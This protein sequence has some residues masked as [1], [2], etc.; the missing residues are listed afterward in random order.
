M[1][2]SVVNKTTTTTTNTTTTTTTGLKIDQLNSLLKIKQNDAASNNK[3]TKTTTTTNNHNSSVSLSNSHSRN[4]ANLRE[5]LELAHKLNQTNSF[6]SSATLDHS[7]KSNDNNGSSTN[8]QS[9]SDLIDLLSS[10]NSTTNNNNN[11]SCSNVKKL[12]KQLLEASK[13]VF[14]LNIYIYIFLC[15]ILK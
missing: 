8:E 9:L 6:S 4:L 12:N 1:K 11:N 10:N 7:H 2:A 5:V 3:M 15:C 13:F 14:F